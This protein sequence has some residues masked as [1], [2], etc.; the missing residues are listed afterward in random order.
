VQDKLSGFLG[1]DSST[2]WQR[3]YAYIDW[4]DFIDISSPSTLFEGVVDY[5]CL[6]VLG[7]MLAVP[8]GFY[9]LF[10]RDSCATR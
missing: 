7:F 10:L 3:G 2:I 1:A 6:M 9:K 5:E 4:L 8:L